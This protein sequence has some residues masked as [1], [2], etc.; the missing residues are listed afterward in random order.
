MRINIIAKS[1][2]KV[3]AQDDRRGGTSKTQPLSWMWLTH[4][5]E[6]LYCGVQEAEFLGF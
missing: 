2:Y 6:C 3:R 5:P 4:A 1:T